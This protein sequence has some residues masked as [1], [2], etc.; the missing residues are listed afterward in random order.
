MPAVSRAERIIW[1]GDTWRYYKG[2]NMPA[3]G[4][5]WA[6][7]G[8]DDS[9]W[10]TGPSGFG[11]GDGDDATLLG[12]MTNSVGGYVTVFIRKTFFVPDTNAVT[13]LTLGA[14]YDDGF[15]AYINGAEVASRTNNGA[16]PISNTTTATGNHEATRGSP[17][18]PKEFLSLSPSVLINGT[19]T[20]AVVGNNVSTNSSDLSLIIEL[21]STGPLIRGP[22]IQMP[23][24]N[25]VTVVWKTSTASDSAV[26]YGLDTGYSA[27]TVSNATLVTNHVMNISGLL[28]GTNYYYR[29]QSGGVTLAAGEYFRTKRTASQSFRF[30]A[31]G[32]WGQGTSGMSNIAARVNSVT[33]LDF[34]ITLGDNIYYAGE[35]S[36]YD[37]YWFSLYGRTLRRSPVFPGIG[38]HDVGDGSNVG[39][40]YLDNFYVP[41]NG[42]TTVANMLERNY[43][44]DYAN[45]HFV[46]FD[47]NTCSNFASVAA[48]G[49]RVAA[50]KTWLSNDLAN[51]TK[52]WKFVYFHHPP[53]TSDGGVHGDNEAV[54]TNLMPIVE[55]AGV[56]FVF[57]GHNHFY[58]RINAINGT[59]HIISG[60]GGA[61]LSTPTNRKSYSTALVTAVNSISVVDIDGTKFKLRQIDSAGTQIDQFQLDLSHPFKIDGLLD[62]SSWLR[63]ENGLKLYAAIR[64]MYLYVATQD[65]G[66]TGDNF[67]YVNNVLSTNRAPNWAKATTNKV[68]QWNCFLADE[69]DSAFQGWFGTTETFHSEFPYFQSMTSGLN[70]NGALGNG[71]LEGTIDLTNRFG[72]FPQQLYVAAAAFANADGGAMTAFVPLAG[73]SSGFLTNFLALNTRD[74][75]LD[76][77][78]ASA[79]A[80]P[81]TVESGYPATLIG[82][83]STSPSGLPL[84]YNWIQLTGPAVTLVNSNTATATFTSAVD[85]NAVLTFQLTINDTRFGSNATTAVT[86]TQIVDT[87]GDGLSNVEED[88]G[89]DNV[90]TTPNPSGFTTDKTKADSDGDGAGD[91]AEALAGTNPNDAAVFLRVTRTT[92]DGG[93]FLVEWNSVAGKTYRVQYRDDLSSGWSDLPGDVTAVT[94]TTNKLDGSA[95]GLP[96][97]YYR[98]IIP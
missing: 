65:A 59:Y 12:D 18:Q 28:P 7:N 1:E 64:G 83:T 89:T 92:L 73:N 78:V 57:D 19:N 72:A 52:P 42:P 33:D 91:G 63:A 98:I 36:L 43:S 5:T 31:F 88:T 17:A 80:S 47:S 56:Q 48:D 26:D 95:V 14:D 54:K 67:V 3:P 87:D 93:G 96:A 39:Q 74:I 46:T 9:A 68:M 82:T 62:S 29:V 51:T 11:Y 35:G 25:E 32:D 81:A 41:T 53:Y 37:P 71:V 61:S 86:L 24:S 55:A 60:A 69:N 97:R 66:E 49:P 34:Y 79:S 58:E 27:G 84:T 75:A 6:T 4:A 30:I 45:A 23:E 90:L 76:L 70:N 40:P 85:T 22:Y 50:I 16:H 2:T 44:F 21:S 94:T 77:P 15:I 20:L 13:T 8:F 38:N 10:P